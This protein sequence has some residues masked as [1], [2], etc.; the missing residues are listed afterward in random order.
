MKKTKNIIP[1]KELNLTDRFLFDEVMEDPEVH[2]A[3]LEIILG[4][5]IQFLDKN[6]TEKE[7]RVSPEIRAVRL[8]VFSMDEEKTVY[9]T[10]MQDSW[11][12]DLAKRSRYYQSML[13]TSLLEPGIPNYNLLNQSYI[14]MIM[15]FDWFGYGK[16]CYT[17]EPKCREVPECVLGDGTTRIFLNTKGKNDDEVSKELVEFLYYIENTTDEA[18]T[19]AGSEKIKR[20]HERVCKVKLSEEI[21]V[22]YMQAWEEKYYERQEGREEGREEGEKLALI[23]LVC[24]KAAKGCS[25]SDIAEIAQI[26]E[27]DENEIRK[28]YDIAVKHGPDYDAEDILK[29][30]ME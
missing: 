15:S 4:R 19:R 10:E 21:G 14:I 8:D 2:Q 23:K 27:I 28:I 6:E 16:Y 1:L 22:K 25:A 26:M 29:E 17:F 5:D 11:K 7:L 20:I 9:G 30:L 12:A 24:K 13:D 3:V 18:A